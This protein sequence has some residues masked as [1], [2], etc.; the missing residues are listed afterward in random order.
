MIMTRLRVHLRLT[1]TALTTGTTCVTMA[2]ALLLGGARLD[3]PIHDTQAHTT[4]PRPA[5]Y[6]ADT[7]LR[8]LIVG[9][10]GTPLLSVLGVD[11]DGRL[12]A[13]AGS[14]FST[15]IFS[16]GLAITPDARTVYTTHTVS[17]Q[18]I[19]YRIGDDGQL[20]QLAGATINAA[21]P[22]VGV[23][24]SPDGRRLFATVG[25]LPVE[26]RSY[27]IA[28]SG[29]LTP[30][31]AAPARVAGAAFS[32]V[33]VT[34]DGRHLVFSD[35]L[36][37]TVSSYAI[38][39]DASLSR[40]GA[41]LPTGEKPV[42]PVF[43]PDGRFVYIS[44]EISGTVSGYAVA[45][46][47]HLTP[48]P[49][50]P[51]VAP[52][53]HGASISPDGRHLY[54]S[55]SGKVGGFAIRED[56]ALTPLPGSPYDAQ[57]S[58]VVLSPD[59]RR[60]FAVD[61][62]TAVRT[63]ARHSDGTLSPTGDPATPTGVVFSD[64]QIAAITPNLGPTA[65][66]TVTS[67]EGAALTFSAAGSHDADGRVARYAW[68]FGDGSRAVTTSPTV[69]HRYAGT[70]SRVATVTVTDDEGCSTELV[71]TGTTASCTGT[72]AATARTPTR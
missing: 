16:L 30:T 10:T 17:G 2:G 43:T 29:D 53:A 31:G 69:T 56:G 60:V 12:S 14:P 38:A 23:A 51:Y 34:P 15:G 47:G 44:D 62:M 48:T 32:Q 19:G 21:G 24:V 8:R 41:P 65:A 22:V 50:S 66:I 70:R 3:A 25:M 13:T 35:W 45:A 57:A 61:G 7:P 9:S 52:T 18:L 42:M 71:Y 26:I 59:G 40:V 39:P 68:T 33:S 64:G 55:D 28:P 4:A 63:L 67:R 11:R 54:V 6:T 1:S 5:A 58:R 36:Q 72:S 20:T 27:D 46:D 37:N 49:G